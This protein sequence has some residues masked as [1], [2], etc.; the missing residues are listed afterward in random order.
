MKWD[1][2]FTAQLD[3]PGDRSVCKKFW[4]KRIQAV[5]RDVG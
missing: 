5:Q 3:A 4:N 1:G 2:T